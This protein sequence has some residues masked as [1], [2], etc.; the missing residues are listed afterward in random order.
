MHRKQDILFDTG[1]AM[2]VLR[3]T[4]VHVEVFEKLE[5]PLQLSWN[6]VH[7]QSNLLVSVTRDDISRRN[8]MR[9]ALVPTCQG[10]SLACRH[11]DS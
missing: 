4:Q 2:I 1:I 8:H 10:S 5:G 6:V 9:D 7:C 11:H 3:G